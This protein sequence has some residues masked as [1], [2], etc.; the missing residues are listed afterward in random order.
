MY[1]KA[2]PIAPAL[3]AHFVHNLRWGSAL[4]LAA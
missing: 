3:L 4:L 1:E 2:M